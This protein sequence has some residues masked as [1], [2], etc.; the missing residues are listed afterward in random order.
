MASAFLFCRVSISL[1]FLII[2]ISVVNSS[3]IPKTWP[4]FVQNCIASF[5]SSSA[6]HCFSN[7]FYPSGREHVGDPEAYGILPVILWDPL[8]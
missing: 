4:D 1:V 7:V 8:V 5:A 6:K 3:N 2:P